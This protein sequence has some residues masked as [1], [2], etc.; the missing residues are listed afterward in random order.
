MVLAGPG[1]KHLVCE[2]GISVDCIHTKP[3]E[4]AANLFYGKHILITNKQTYHWIGLR[5]ILQDTSIFNGKIHGFL[6]IV[7]ENQ[8]NELSGSLV[9][10]KLNTNLRALVPFPMNVMN[11]PNGL[12][13]AKSQEK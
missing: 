4:I 12:S 1:Q 9:G 3:W 13:T 2:L 10:I 11:Q 8:S 6:S 5:E 7:P